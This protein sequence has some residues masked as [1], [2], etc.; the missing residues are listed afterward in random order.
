MM[1]FDAHS[2]LQDARLNRDVEGVLKRA[3][4]A[5]VWRIVSCGARV[6]DW[7]DLLELS[8]KYDAIV[9]AFGVHPLY[10]DGLR[11]EW[12][13]ELVRFLKAVPHAG[14]GEIGLDFT[15]D[16]HDRA[17]QE[18]V[19][20]EQLQVAAEMGRVASIHCRGAWGRLLEILEKGTGLQA[21]FVV[22]SYSGSVE[23]MARLTR[24]GGCFSFSGAIT[25]KGN[26]RGIEALAAAP[27]DRVLSE[28]DSPDILPEGS[29]VAR[30][31]AQAE[32]RVNEPANL[33]LIMA[34][35]ALVRKMDAVSAAEMIFENSMRLFKPVSATVKRAL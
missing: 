32:A 4:L 26:R 29:P 13:H 27:A 16:G 1:L 31:E 17:L 35:I 23:S 34:K 14:V 8:R 15:V 30:G 21:G 7:S 6:E 24:L 11:A 3:L 22:H 12:K 5:G 19:F 2:H 18:E 28:T 25:R 33:P 9:P 20:I 10:L